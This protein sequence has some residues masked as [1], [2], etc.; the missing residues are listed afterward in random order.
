M[1]CKPDPRSDDSAAAAF[2]DI[3]VDKYIFCWMLRNRHESII[4][5]EFCLTILKK[6]KET[7]LQAAAKDDKIDDNVD[8]ICSC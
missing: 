8:M 4:Y 1:E 3:C 6:G 5:F 2:A 7:V